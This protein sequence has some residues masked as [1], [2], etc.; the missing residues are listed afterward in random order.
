MTKHVQLNSLKIS[1]EDCKKAYC[2]NINILK[3]KTNRNLIDEAGLVR[4]SGMEQPHKFKKGIYPSIYSQH[5]QKEN[6][7]DLMNIKSK[8]KRHPQS[9]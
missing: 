3:I 6:K 5:K 4:E 1:T 9:F 8:F 7:L 2:N